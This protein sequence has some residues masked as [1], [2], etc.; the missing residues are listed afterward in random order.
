[1]STSTL[2]QYYA[3]GMY[4]LWD[5]FFGFLYNANGKDFIIVILIL[6]GVIGIVIA[7]IK[8]VFKPFIK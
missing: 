3:D 4:Y 1:M 7:G 5:S 6:V 2:Q 8:W